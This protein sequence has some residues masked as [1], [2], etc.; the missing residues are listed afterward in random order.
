[1]ARTTVTAIDSSI[2]GATISYSN[3]DASN[4]NN[5]LFDADLLVLAKNT[6]SSD[7]TV[8]L[9]ANGATVNGIA[10][11]DVTITIPATSGHKAIDA[12]PREFFATSGYLN[13]DWSSATGMTFC[14]MKK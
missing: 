1:M 9:R 6:D 12:I 2:A 4:G 13:I 8:T 14:V 7:H 11:P 3:A 5:V 10:I